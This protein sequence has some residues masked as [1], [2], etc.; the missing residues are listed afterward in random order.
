[1]K[2]LSIFIIWVYQHTLSF[3]HGPIRRIFGQ[4]TPRICRYEPTCS[5]YATLALK[6]YGFLKGWR[7]AG[8]RILRCHPFSS[9]PHYDPVP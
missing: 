2:T 6:K 7:L 9:H 5:E 4:Y 1:M 3:E 8:I